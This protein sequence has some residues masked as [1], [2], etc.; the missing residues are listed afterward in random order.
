M[1]L[2]VLLIGSK[3]RPGRDEKVTYVRENGVQRKIVAG[4]HADKDLIWITERVGE[5]V[6]MSNITHNLGVMAAKADLYYPLWRPGEVG[7][8]V[9]RQLI[10]PLT[11]GLSKL[12][13]SPDAYRQYNPTNGW[14]SYE[15]LVNF[16]RNYLE[17][18]EQNGE[19]MIE[20]LR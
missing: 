15:G 9:A 12:E 7:I 4:E 1:S 10:Q 16:T 20:V 3:E 2:T 17:A 13:S 8:K 5:C 6:Y 19:A 11:D 14:G 18:C